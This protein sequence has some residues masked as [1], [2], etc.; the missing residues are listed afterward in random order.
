[1]LRAE[2]RRQRHRRRPLKQVDGRTTVPVEAG[3]VGDEADARAAEE[4]EL[5]AGE[6][7]DA[8]E[9]RR[10]RTVVSCGGGGRHGLRGSFRG[11]PDYTA[12]GARRTG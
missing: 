6:H 5:V 7:V 8:G 3:V 4:R 9:D 2:Q 11:M 1:V 12:G 10:P